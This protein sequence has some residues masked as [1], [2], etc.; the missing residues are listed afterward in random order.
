MQRKIL[1]FLIAVFMINSQT[2]SQ[3]YE[4]GKRTKAQF[5]NVLHLNPTEY[6]IY[7]SPLGDLHGIQG[8]SAGEKFFF[9]WDNFFIY[10]F[11]GNTHQFIDKIKIKCISVTDVNGEIYCL[12]HQL[13]I[14]NFSKLSHSYQILDQFTCYADFIKFRENRSQKP[15]QAYRIR[16]LKYF[17]NSIFLYS[18]NGTF[19]KIP[20]DVNIEKSTDGKNYIFPKVLH[21]IDR[22]QPPKHPNKHLII[23]GEISTQVTKSRSQC[24]V[25]FFNTKTKQNEKFILKIPLVGDQKTALA[26]P[27][28]IFGSSEHL[29]FL[30][31]H[32]ENN[33]SDDVIVYLNR[34]LNKISEIELPSRT[35]DSNL[36]HQNDTFYSNG[37]LY[38][39]ASNPDSSVDVLRLEV[40]FDEKN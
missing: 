21:L 31:G 20:D 7:E 36:F 26:E 3:K 5:E 9:I 13:F 10:V 29:F 14:Y 15:P 27:Y 40:K 23:N 30:F 24:I 34:A 17:E 6:R 16:D 11:D 22:S 25:D 8:M 4:Y 32:R 37:F 18:N 19:Y 35:H 33:V 28:F 2:F 12:G 1:F 39:M 38:L